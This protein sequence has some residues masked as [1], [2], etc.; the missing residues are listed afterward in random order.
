MIKLKW[1]RHVEIARARIVK[2]IGWSAER[3]AVKQ[4]ADELV[5]SGHGEKFLNAARR[6]RPGVTRT[7]RSQLVEQVE[8]MLA[9]KRRKPRIRAKLEQ[10]TEMELSP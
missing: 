6:G 1:Q 4:L 7:L 3:D 8:K 2:T 9:V 10:T 5:A